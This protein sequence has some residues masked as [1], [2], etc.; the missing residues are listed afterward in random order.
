[1]FYFGKIQKWN[2]QIFVNCMSIIFLYILFLVILYNVLYIISTSNN[3]LL[4]VDLCYIIL[5]LLQSHYYHC[6]YT[7]ARPW[8]MT[9]IKPAHYSFKSR[10]LL[11]EVTMWFS[12]LM[13]PIPAL[14][15]KVIKGSMV[16]SRSDG[17]SERP[18]PVPGP[19]AL[20]LS[21]P[22]PLQDILCT[23]S[24]SLQFS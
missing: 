19:P 9:V 12:H 13:T 24:S 21:S 23:T 16:C 18:S 4:F 22:L 5:F 17:G 7:T 14:P 15:D 8:L 11:S 1:M 2:I 3:I 20:G 10:L 6:Y